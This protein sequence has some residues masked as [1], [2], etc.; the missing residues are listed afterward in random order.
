MSII[1][2]GFFLSLLSLVLAIDCY[3][4][5]FY[6]CGDSYTNIPTGEDC[7]DVSITEQ[8]IERPQ[9]LDLK[10]SY[11][12]PTY[13]DSQTNSGSYPSR[14]GGTFKGSRRT[15]TL[16][17]VIDGDT[18]EVELEGKLVRVRYKGIDCPEINQKGGK[19]ATEANKRMLGSTLTLI[20][21][22]YTGGYGRLGAYV[23]YGS[24]TVNEEL[25]KQ[26]YCMASGLEFKDAQE[27]ARVY[28]EGI[29]RD[30]NQQSPSEFRQS[31]PKRIKKYKNRT[32]PFEQ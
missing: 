17:R 10:K 11:S 4:A 28:R 20:T 12:S 29:W 23:E 30:D 2:K 1:F 8:K 18:I 5:S 22:G 21:D 15:A 3:G 14:Y 19:E 25:V 16:K 26:G 31:H 7:T 6:K 13:P 32:K 27:S 24:S 9:S